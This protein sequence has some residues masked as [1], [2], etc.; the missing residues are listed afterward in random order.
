M[1]YVNVVVSGQTD[2]AL[3]RVIAQGVTER[4][5]RILRKR[6]E[7]TAVSVTFGAAEQWFVDNRSLDELGLATFWLD[8][9][10]TDRTNTKDEKAAYLAAVFAFMSEVLG[11]LHGT[12]YVRVM[13][14]RAEAW[15]YGG[16]SQK[17][18]AARLPSST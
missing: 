15:G 1:P 10:V 2:R 7:V 18:R 17:E 5:A 9:A 8:I 12:S 3:A 4:T 13:D 11:P 14:V 6:P 16:L